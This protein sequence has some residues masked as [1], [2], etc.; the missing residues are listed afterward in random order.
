MSGL[1]RAEENGEYEDFAAPKNPNIT[2]VE[3]NIWLY[4][5]FMG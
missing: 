1:R 4:G 2:P 5:S 3:L